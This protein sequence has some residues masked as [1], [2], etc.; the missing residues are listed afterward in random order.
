LVGLLL[1]S[2]VSVG[3]KA[4]TVRVAEVSF[5]SITEGAVRWNVVSGNKDVRDAS[6][7]VLLGNLLDGKLTGW[8]D[9]GNAAGFV[10]KKDS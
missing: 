8:D 6:R 2:E 9:D 7:H 4:V 5:P 10:G 1:G 3:T